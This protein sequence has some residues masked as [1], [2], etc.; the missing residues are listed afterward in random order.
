MQEQQNMKHND[1]PCPWR[2]KVESKFGQ[3]HFSPNGGKV[4]EKK[5]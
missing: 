2:E 1:Y 5:R 4:G 3:M